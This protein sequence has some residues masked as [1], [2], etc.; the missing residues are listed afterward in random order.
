MEVEVAPYW[1]VNSDCRFINV[2]FDDVEVA[3]Y[4]NVN[5]DIMK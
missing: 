4:W 3:P 2:N 1:N 5:K